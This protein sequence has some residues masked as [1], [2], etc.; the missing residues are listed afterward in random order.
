MSV[1]SREYNKLVKAMRPSQSR[2]SG[3]SSG[4]KVSVPHVPH[5]R[6]VHPSPIF[7]RRAGRITSPL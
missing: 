5:H 7:S 6:F 1:F 3:G 2:D 4:L